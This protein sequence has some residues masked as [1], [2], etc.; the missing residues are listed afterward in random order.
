[1]VSVL[2]TAM[3]SLGW[4]GHYLQRG[5]REEVGAEDSRG[6]GALH[7]WPLFAATIKTYFHFAA[8][9]WLSLHLHS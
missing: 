9:L 2:A 8:L 6:G 4:G 1:M 7:I 5:E 3:A